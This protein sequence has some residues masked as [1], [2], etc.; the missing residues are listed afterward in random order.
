MIRFL[1]G[2]YSVMAILGCSLS[3]A[4]P[5]DNIKSVIDSIGHVYAPDKRV[6]IYDLEVQAGVLLGET[7]LIER[8]RCVTQ[9]KR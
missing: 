3:E 8:L 4:E 1:F 5:V 7:N 2:L 9:A 6:A